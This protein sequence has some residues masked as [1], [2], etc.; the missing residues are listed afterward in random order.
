MRLSLVLPLL[1]RFTPAAASLGWDMDQEPLT[2]KFDKAAC[3]D[4]ARYA[5]FPQ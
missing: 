3:P 1:A 2:G 4:Y 5:T